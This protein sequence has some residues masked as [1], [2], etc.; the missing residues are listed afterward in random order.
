MVDQIGTS[1]FQL[2]T[3]QFQ[4]VSR[5]PLIAESGFAPGSIHVGFVAD[6]VALGQVFLRVF[7]L[8]VLFHR[9]PYLYIIWGMNNMSVNGSSSETQVSPHNNQSINQLN[10]FIPLSCTKALTIFGTVNR[11]FNKIQ[12]FILGLLFSLIHRYRIPG[13]CF[14][15]FAMIVR[16]DDCWVG[17]AMVLSHVKD[18]IQ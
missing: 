13:L 9:P 5:R 15:Y 17:G 1:W 14:V 8:S 11:L 18:D 16:E 3:C 10:A 4:V 2:N 12:L 7:P 6:Q